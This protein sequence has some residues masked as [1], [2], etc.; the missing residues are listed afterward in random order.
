VVVV[1]LLLLLLPPES[2]S[3]MREL[4]PRV[5]VE[6][7]SGEV[8]VVIERPL[9]HHMVFLRPREAAAA[10]VAWRTVRHSGPHSGHQREPCPPRESTATAPPSPP[11]PVSSH[12][13]LTRRKCHQL[14]PC[15]RRERERERETITTWRVGWRWR[16]SRPSSRT[17]V[18]LHSVP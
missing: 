1:L 11:P 8:V 3:R 10:P 7:A 18:R 15:D 5:R 13:H 2:P 9:D 16:P 12:L 4:A 6:V 14:L 17:L